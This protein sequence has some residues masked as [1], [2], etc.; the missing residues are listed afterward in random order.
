[1][2]SRFGDEHMY[3]CHEEDSKDKCFLCK[4]SCEKTYTVR[5]IKSQK[6]VHLCG[7]CMVNNIS[8]YI[9]DNTRPWV[10]QD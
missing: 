7:G 1:M 8:D 2:K 10:E 5:E 3:E 4:Q 9:I 6:M